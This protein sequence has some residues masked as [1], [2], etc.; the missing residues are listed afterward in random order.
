[1]R[2]WRRKVDRGSHVP[3]SASPAWRGG[4]RRGDRSDR[5]GVLRVRLA[6]EPSTG[7]GFRLC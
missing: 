2:S 1:M 5:G 7:G 4:V 3:E 6:R